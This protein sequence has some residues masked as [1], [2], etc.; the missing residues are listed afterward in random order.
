MKDILPMCS[1]LTATQ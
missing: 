1:L